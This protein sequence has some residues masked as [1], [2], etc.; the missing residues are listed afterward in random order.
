MARSGGRQSFAAVAP[1]N[2]TYA[3]LIK[4]MSLKTTASG[5]YTNTRAGT[6]SS[7][8]ITLP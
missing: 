2:G 6:Y 1:D 3:Y 5:R 8:E 4:A 7:T